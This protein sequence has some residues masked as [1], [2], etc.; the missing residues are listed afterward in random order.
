MNNEILFTE[1][2]KFRQVWLW[3]ILVGANLIS[4]FGAFRQMSNGIPLLNPLTGGRL[5]TIV[6]LLLVTG[7]IF[8]IRMDTE[9]RTDGLY[10][11]F[12]PINLKMKRY[13]WYTIS[14][15]FVRKYNPL[16]EYGGWGIRLGSFGNGAAFNISGNKG[17]QLVFKNGD[18]VLIGTQKPDEAT[19]VLA[20]LKNK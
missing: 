18:K 14:E 13:S 7:L 16:M 19:I 6:I 3:V 10:I 2:Q 17:I 5:T 9:I 15:A 12:Y 4:I 8:M 11:R 20:Q 1:T